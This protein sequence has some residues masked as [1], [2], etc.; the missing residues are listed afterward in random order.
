MI[1]CMVRFD[2]NSFLLLIFCFLLPAA[3]PARLLSAPGEHFKL[4]GLHVAGSKR[5]A[6]ADI[7]RATGL[8]LGQDI[9]TQTLQEVSSRLASTGVFK[10]VTYRYTTRGS[11]MTVEFHVED[12]DKFFP[13]SFLNFVWFA[14][15][16]LQAGL[17]SRVPLFEGEVPAN[18]NLAEQISTALEA[19]L[20]EKGVEGRV[21]FSGEGRLGGPVERITFKVEGV[22]LPVRAIHFEG[23]TH[24]DASTLEQ[25]TRPLVGQDYDQAMLLDYTQYNVAPLYTSRGYLR[26]SFGNPSTRLTQEGS[27]RS[28]VEVTLPVTEGLQYRLT[29]IHW[30]GN[31]VF[32]ASELGKN[33]H[34][35]PGQPVNA[36]QLKDDLD[37]ISRLYGTRG[38]LVASV[39]PKPQLDDA[40]QTATYELEVHEG[41]LYHMGKL[42]IAG[43]EPARV[44]ALKEA[45]RLR[46][47]DAFDTSY[48]KT[49]I[50]E[51]DRYL[52]RLPGGWE[53][54]F[55]QAVEPASKTVDV[56]I[57]F[58]PKGI[59]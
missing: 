17:R 18:G 49:F 50:Q 21:R 46:P 52:P 39:R 23:N 48:W 11:Q 35:V 6:E 7:I 58:A 30:S 29:E 8:A 4:F 27:Q 56:T 47:G 44:A 54:K 26:V 43:I 13:C 38:Y 32:P 24:L 45:C 31:T 51:I 19:M 22:P 12:A 42:E 55:T 3:G 28:S 15:Q 33:V 2:R 1:G 14:S 9:S 57:S 20:K 16:E 40:T 25:A 41:D 36:I 34:V 59:R 5:F 10:G 37:D 53:M